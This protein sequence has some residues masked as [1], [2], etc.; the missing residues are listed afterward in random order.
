MVAVTYGRVAARAPR[1][2]AHKSWATQLFKALMDAR[3]KQA[4]REIARYPHLLDIK[5]V[6]FA[7]PRKRR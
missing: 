6:Q 3:Q 4:E 7:P 5:P 1:K 2:A